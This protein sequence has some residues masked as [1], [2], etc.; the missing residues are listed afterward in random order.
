MSFVCIPV[1]LRR[2]TLVTAGLGRPGD[3][4]P[5]DTG[6]TRAPKNARTGRSYHLGGASLCGRRIRA[7][8]AGE[9]VSET[10]SEITVA[11]VIVSANCR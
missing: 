8:S 6:D 1:G 5:H 11:L 7:Q 10:I 2:S 3:R 4:Q 9:S